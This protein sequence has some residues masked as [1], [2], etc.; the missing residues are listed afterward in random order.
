MLLAQLD[1]I[2]STLASTAD[3]WSSFASLCI[4]INGFSVPAASKI[5]FLK[6]IIDV[7]ISEVLLLS[8][9][10]PVIKP[11]LELSKAIGKIKKSGF[12]RLPVVYKKNVVGM[13]TVKD[14]LMIDPSS[15]SSI[16]NFVS[17]KEQEEKIRRRDS[18]GRNANL[19][20][21]REGL[22]EECG[23]YDLLYK[24]DGGVICESCRDDM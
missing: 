1:V 14:I 9:K 19:R 8:K 17:V 2:G 5:G 3:S 24:V 11:N 6:A 18:L 10:V 12:R 7:L 16:S 21:S 20:S 22:C 15:Y 13:L 4:C 23:N